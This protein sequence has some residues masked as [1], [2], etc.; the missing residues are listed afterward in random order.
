MRLSKGL[1]LLIVVSITMFLIGFAGGI[2]SAPSVGF[3]RVETVTRQVPILITQTITAVNTTTVTSTITETATHVETYTSTVPVTTTIVQTAFMPTTVTRTETLTL[4]LNMPATYA[5]EPS[6]KVSRGS[7][8][9]VND[10]TTSI[11]TCYRQVVANTSIAIVGNSSTTIARNSTYY[12]I[13]LQLRNDAPW[14]RAIDLAMLSKVIL[15]TSSGRSYEPIAINATKGFI[16]PGSYG[17]AEVVFSI[18]EN[19][20]PSYLYTEINVN[21]M[22]VRVE[23][24]L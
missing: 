18:D 11:A 6:A 19:E 17:F 3:V 5:T 23:F 10:W 2:F 8:I 20:S 13:V 21:G 12:V 24:E 7:S 14:A 1:V 9:K 4:T 16:A 22:I 15:V